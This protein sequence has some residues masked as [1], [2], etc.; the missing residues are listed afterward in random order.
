[1][2]YLMAET[3]R[4]RE[5]DFPI[6]GDLLWRYVAGRTT[7]QETRRIAL[8]IRRDAELRRSVAVLREQHEVMIA[9]DPSVLDEDVPSRLLEVLVR[10]RRALEEGHGDES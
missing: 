4:R 6:G 10:A 9:G 8:M 1:M 2:I 3:M 7:V 5:R